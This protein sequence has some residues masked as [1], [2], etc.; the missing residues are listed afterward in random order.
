ME[1][2]TLDDYLAFNEQLAALAAAGV[3]LDIDLGSSREDATKTLARIDAT[4]ARRVKRGE[5]LGEALEGDEGDLPSSYRSLVQVGLHDGNLAA[6]LDESSAVAESAVAS[7]TSLVSA[8]TYPLAVCALAYVGLLVLCLYF[9]P[10]LAALYQ[11]V[12][13]SPSSSLQVLAA[14]RSTLPYWAVIVPVVLVA[15]AVYLFRARKQPAIGNAVAGLLS[16]I[17]GVSR[18]LFHERCARLA[19]TLA[20][21]L[22]D[23]VALPAALRIAGDGC[24]DASLRASAVQMASAGGEQSPDSNNIIATAFPPFLRWALG[25]ADQ[26]TDRVQALEI[27]TRLYRET[28]ERRAARFRAIAPAVLLV[29]VGGTVTLLY[30]LA[31]FV[32]MVQL[33]YGLS[34]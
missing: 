14:L 6:G 30:G 17:P 19:A 22:R 16:W 4:V 12:R 31:L 29:F 25:H 2:A 32:P 9:E 1:S 10:T 8:F 7:Q 24:G 3:P 20:D 33:L 27:A 28:A 11:D 13:L 34:R 5:T 23:G 15:L 26:T 21:L 18:S